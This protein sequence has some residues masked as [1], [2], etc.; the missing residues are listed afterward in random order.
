MKLPQTED[1]NE[2]LPQP[3][4]KLERTIRS[5]KIEVQALARETDEATMERAQSIREEI[6]NMEESA[7]NSSP[8]GKLKN[9][10]SKA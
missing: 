5:K 2:S 10:P 7:M 3:I 1:G 9:Q 4:D 8:N 6:A